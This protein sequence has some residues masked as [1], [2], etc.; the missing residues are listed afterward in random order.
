MEMK[1]DRH[2]RESWAR[3]NP[4]IFNFYFLAQPFSP[5]GRG[6]MVREKSRTHKETDNP[7]KIFFGS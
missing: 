3:T 4:T 5:G 7:G 6:V 1:M 2:H